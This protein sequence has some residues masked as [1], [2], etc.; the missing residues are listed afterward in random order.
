M[1][2]RTVDETVRVA[3]SPPSAA[4]PAP[5]TMQLLA[6]RLSAMACG[7]AITVVLARGLGPADFGVYGVI[8][9]VLTV[10]E[11]VAGLGI[12]GATTKLIPADPRNAGAVA[13][14]RGSSTCPTARR[15]SGSPCSTC[16]SW[17]SWSRTSPHCTAMVASA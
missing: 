6:G 9:S 7:Y 12:P 10:V 15:C 5:G 13:C 11:M 8:I 14:S 3:A 17:R 16:R 4:A 1:S 2:T